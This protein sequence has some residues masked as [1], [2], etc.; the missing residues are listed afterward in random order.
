MTWCPTTVT[1]ACTT[2]PGW[3]ANE[4]VFDG[5]GTSSYQALETA[6]PAALQSTS[7]P[8][9]SSAFEVGL[10]PPIPTHTAE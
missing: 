5:A 1:V 4:I 7:V 10:K 2:S 3:T 8:I 6:F 9:C